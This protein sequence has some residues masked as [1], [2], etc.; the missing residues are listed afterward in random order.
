MLIILLTMSAQAERVIG[1]GIIRMG[2]SIL[3]APCDIDV[4][5][6]EQTVGLGIETTGDLRHN[7]R[8]PGRQIAIHLVNCRAKLEDEGRAR[9]FPFT[10]T[11]D[12]TPDQ[13][14]FGV[15]GAS[16]IGLQISDTEGNVVIP[17]QPIPHQTVG[18][19]GMELDYI[20]RLVGEHSRLL[21]GNYHTAIRYKIDY[22]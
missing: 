2:G 13:S 20:V 16:G 1:H 4:A 9:M 22:F 19:E 21:A 18:F 10:V 11:F 3:E 8:E 15:E 5:D 17:G 12:G 7:A 6:R 14:L